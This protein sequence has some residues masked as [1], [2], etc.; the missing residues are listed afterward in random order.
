MTTRRRKLPD[1]RLETILDQ[2]YSY[3]DPA[4][5][6][7]H[8]NVTEGMKQAKT[9]GEL[10]PILL[11]EYGITPE[12]VHSQYQGL[13]EAY[14]LTTDLDEPLLFVPFDDKVRLIDGWHRLLNAALTG[15]EILPAYFLTYEEA[16]AC[17][18]CCLP[19]GEGFDWG[20]PSRH[21]AAAALH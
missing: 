11:A 21:T 2:V 5:W 1:I 7:F 18:V 17:L 4:G 14:A 6:Q 20:Q 15:V 16:D 8:W 13:D 19:P 3:E 10:C 12:F 9:T